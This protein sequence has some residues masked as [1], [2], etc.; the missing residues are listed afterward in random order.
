MSE[1]TGAVR[2][3]IIMG[4]VSVAYLTLTVLLVRREATVLIGVIAPT[5]VAAHL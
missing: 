4:A 2:R 3:H 5:I 1:D